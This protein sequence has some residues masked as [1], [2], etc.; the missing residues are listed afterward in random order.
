[1]K[2]LLALTL[3]CCAAPS[4]AEE[5]AL[6]TEFDSSSELKDLINA[7]KE[8]RSINKERVQRLKELIK[9][10]GWTKNAEKKQSDAEQA[11]A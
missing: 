3:I 10:R 9:E 6:A 8:D 11:P 4:F 7:M 2:F 1:M 5:E